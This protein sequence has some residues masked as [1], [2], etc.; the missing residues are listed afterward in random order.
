ML[1]KLINLFTYYFN[2]IYFQ[3]FKALH[4][5][6]I[7]YIEYLFLSETEIAEI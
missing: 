7:S 5:A 4:D 6:F 2:N 3:I 1:F